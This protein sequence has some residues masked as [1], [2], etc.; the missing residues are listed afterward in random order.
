M[1][2]LNNHNIRGRVSRLSAD[3]VLGGLIPRDIN[4]PDY[5]IPIAALKVLNAYI[6]TVFWRA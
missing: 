6:Q 2:F 4:I 1:S 5:N 3:V